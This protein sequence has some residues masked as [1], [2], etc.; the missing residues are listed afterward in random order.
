M[1]KGF[2]L[3]FKE[4]EDKSKK[5]STRL[6]N[7]AM[8]YVK[9]PTKFFSTIITNVPRNLISFITLLSAIPSDYITGKY[10]DA[11][12]STAHVLVLVIGKIE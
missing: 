1:V 10:Y 8:S 12:E 2:P 4:C 11:G 7:W 9:Q 6:K 5:D 3:L